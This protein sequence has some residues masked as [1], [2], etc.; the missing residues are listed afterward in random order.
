VEIVQATENDIPT[1]V[2]FA[3]KFHQVSPF[4]DSPFSPE[5]VELFCQ[6]LLTNGINNAILLLSVAEGEPT[7]MLIASA[8]EMSFSTDRFAVELAWWVEPEYRNSPAAQR[9]IEV[10][11]YWA[12][13]V[14]CT[15]VM[16]SSLSIDNQKILDRWYSRRGYRPTEN[17]YTKELS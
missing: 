1:I 9:L 12:K 5:M 11:E 2:E 4:Q 7:G 17:H 6:T 10:Y 3:R 15:H 13:K 8:Q 16:M 14:G